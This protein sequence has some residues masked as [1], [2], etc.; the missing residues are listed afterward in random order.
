MTSRTH[1]RPSLPA[2]LSLIILVALFLAACGATE[3]PGQPTAPVLGTPG[4]TET[5]MDAD[6]P[7]GTRP[8]GAFD[9][10][11]EGLLRVTAFPI[12]QTDPAFIS[13]DAE[14]LIASQVYDYLLDVD[15]GNEIQP[16]LAT[17]WTQGED[18][19]TYTFAL[20]EGVTFH[21]GSPFSAQDV[22][23]TFDRLRDPDSGY[24]TADLYR[25]IL[26]IQATGDLEVTFTL[27]ETNPFFLY[28]LSD[29]H[30]LILKANTE[31]PGDWN[32]TGP[33]VVTA[34]QPESRIVMQ[35]NERYFVE[36]Q[37]RLAELQI[38]FFSDQSAAADA[39][40][41][42]QADLIMDLSTPLYEGLRDRSGLE[43]LDIPTNQFAVVRLRTDQPP[44]DDPRV[45]EA[46]KLATDLEA[47]FRLVQQGYGAVGRNTPI[48]PVYR[49]YYTE[50]V[51]VPGRD[52]DAAR[53]LLADAGYPDGLDIDLHLLS[54][55]NFPDLAVVLKEQW[56]G[57]GINA[58]VVTLPESVYYGQDQWLE[59]P[60]GITGWG[61]RPY[62]Q[63]YLDVML[64]CDAI[65]NETRFC[66]PE[67][68]RLAALAGRSL[69]EQE[70]VEAY[71]EIQR[72]LIE[73][74]PMIVP[75][76]FAQYAVIREG[77]D[78]FELH[79]FSG[80][81]DLRQVGVR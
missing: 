7:F 27:S 33:F 4:G 32:G 14:V 75:Y 76:F 18:G 41:G 77:F 61:H 10:V 17:G 67:F 8:P 24:P 65:W 5:P 21:D 13:S 57:A 6:T 58:N 28:D 37:P 3:E 9:D 66:H 16:R 44:G 25:N 29:N 81:T 34:Y 50:D 36:G 79:P 38:L 15:A 39:V 47:I 42:G 23:W 72:I 70:R 22:V 69:D 26:D 1:T 73:E 63:F 31:N 11:R 53:Q 48:G 55:L 56:A 54:T 52:P 30:A 78:G 12:A 62:P 68:D 20:A 64:T 74:G 80:R 40:R 71:H 59:V 35:A 46:F 43:A 49:E 51:P 45:V 19:L 2:V 60:L